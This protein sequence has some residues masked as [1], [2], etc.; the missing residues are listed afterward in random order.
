MRT[1]LI[2]LLSP[3]FN[4]QLSFPSI[5]KHPPIQTFPSKRA[6][7]TLDERILPRAAG[8]DVQRATL[9]IAQPLLQRV[10]NKLWTIIAAQISRRT[11]Q[12]EQPIQHTNDLTGGNRAGNVNG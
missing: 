11:P 12:Q 8:R 4:D 10:G 9:L 1:P 5:G 7:E 2:V 6:I 3:V